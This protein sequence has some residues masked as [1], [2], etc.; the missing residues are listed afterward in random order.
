MSLN[1][2]LANLNRDLAPR[3]LAS[4]YLFPEPLSPREV[5]LG[6]E[7]FVFQYYP[8]NI[9]DTY[10]PEWSTK[11][12]PG[13]SHPLYQ[14]VGGTGRDITF[15]ARFTAERD[16]DDFRGRPS[17]LLPSDRYTVDVRGALARLRSY[18]LPSYGNQEGSGISS[19]TRPPRK[20]HLT[21]EGLGIGGEDE[22]TILVILR[23]APITYE[24][25][26]PN[27]HP[28]VVEVSITVSQ[29]VQHTRSGPGSSIQFIGRDAFE[30]D[31]R[32][33]Q[34]KGATDRA[35]GG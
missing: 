8:D 26:F 35:L 30:S 16:L 22:D 13:G 21:L 7:I 2:I 27:G 18:M 15:T 5:S 29:I 23:S 25:S 12:V 32:N 10:N 17:G 28:R 3:A 34:Y 20:L 14:W 6:D 33:Y 1:A 24:S 9:Q 31:G 4:A 19:R 11:Q